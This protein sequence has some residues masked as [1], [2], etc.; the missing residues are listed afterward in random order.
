MVAGRVL[1][2][3][4]R[5]VL[6]P[7]AVPA[8]QRGR[9]AAEVALPPAEWLPEPTGV[10]P[11]VQSGFETRLGPQTKNE[12]VPLTVPFGPASVARS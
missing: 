10:P 7:E 5:A 2:E 11:V 8:G 3:Q 6:S 9:K 1:R 12:T 4:I